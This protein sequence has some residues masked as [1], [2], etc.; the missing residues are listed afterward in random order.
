[1]AGEHM[2]GLD[3]LY[4]AEEP[5]ASFHDASMLELRLDYR[6]RTASALFELYVGDPAAADATARERTRIGIME[7]TGLIFWVQEPPTLDGRAELPWLTGDGPLRD[8]ETEIGQDLARQ[9]P[10]EA[11][12]WCLYFSDWNACAYCAAMGL[13]FRWVK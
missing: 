9:V 7:L 2:R 4:G 5:H 3:E 8:T 11:W 12:A 10:P 1:M 13:I 6:A